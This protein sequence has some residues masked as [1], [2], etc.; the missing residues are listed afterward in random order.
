MAFAGSRALI[1]GGTGF[2]GSHLADALVKQGATV[3]ILDDFSNGLEENIGEALATGKARLV[4]GSV[5]DYDLVKSLVKDADFIFHEA[6]LNLLRSLENPANDLRVNTG[7][8][9]N[10]LM[11]IKD[12][13][14][15]CT[16]VFASTGSVY[17][18]PQYNPQDENHP[19]RPVSPYGVSKLAAEHYIGLWTR[20]YN[21]R[22]VMLRYYN[23]Y[24]PRQN[25][26]KKGGVIG[27]FIDKVMRGEPPIIEGT[28]GNER[29]FTFVDDVVKANLLAATST[30]AQGQAINI[31]N[32]EITTI[33]ALAEMVIKIG[34]KDLKSAYAPAR[35]GDIAT[36]RPDISL[37]EKLLG[38]R[39]TVMI[40][41]GLQKTLDWFIRTG[42]V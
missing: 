3:T 5:E 41:E 31:G 27:I 20:L 33:K 4:R 21:A 37:A 24:G 18:E 13:N 9:L 39:P 34:K 19:L 40:R 23:V 11:S 30:K 42:K 1:T 25:Y 36:F 8:T 32:T 17:G 26:G 6:A 14:P 7:G 12:L 38:Y 22:A 29:C 35:L 28:G 16:L 2:I 10:I 15:K